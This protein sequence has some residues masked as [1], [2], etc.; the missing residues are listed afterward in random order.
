MK[1]D[2]QQY[3]IAD[4]ALLKIINEQD[5]KIKDIIGRIE[6]LIW[7]SKTEYYPYDKDFIVKCLQEI[8]DENKEKE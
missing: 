6:G 3:V 5:E 7:G 4:K 8:V 2:T 1:K